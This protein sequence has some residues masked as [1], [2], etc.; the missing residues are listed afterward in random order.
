VEMH[1]GKIWVESEGIGKGSRFSFELPVKPKDL[2]EEISEA[3]KD[4]PAIEITSE[5][6]LL[7]H[8]NRIISLSKRHNRHFALC[9]LHVNISYLKDLKEKAQAIKDVM[10]KETRGHDFWGT[11]KDGYI[12]LILHE[13]DR[14]KAKFPCDRFKKKLET[15][16]GGPK[17][18]YSIASFPEDG[19]IPETLM[20]KITIT[21]T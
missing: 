18:S 2:K 21:T 6:T 12:Y 5:A 13:V 7:N 17:I 14:Q 15:V 9:R 8:L 4:R 11:D 1:G 20:R 19:G 16:L 10:E 3:E